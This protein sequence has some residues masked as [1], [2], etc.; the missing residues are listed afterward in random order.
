MKVPD[1]TLGSVRNFVYTELQTLYSPAELRII[2]DALCEVFSSVQPPPAKLSESE[3]LL[4]FN[5]VKKLKKGMPYQYVTK[6]VHFYGLQ[7][8]VNEYTLIPRPETEELADLILK[9]HPNAILHVTDACTG[10]GCIPLALQSRRPQWKIQGFDLFPETLAV[11][12]K[13]AVRTG[14]PVSFFRADALDPDTYVRLEKTDILVSNPPYISAA[15]KTDMHP[16]VLDF[17]PQQALFPE[18]TDPLLFYRRLALGATQCLKKGGF[19]YAEINQYLSRE[20]C[21]VLQEAG[22]SNVQA[23]KDLSGNWRFVSAQY[24]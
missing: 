16:N 23:H 9:N 8:F 4:F 3:L 2:W 1:N 11:A 20:T 13:N 18:G 14:L 7:L 6:N 10:S 22:L 19:F 21:R 24:L 15:E 12:E 5:A 17:E